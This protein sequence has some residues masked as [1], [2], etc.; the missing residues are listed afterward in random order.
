MRTH[1]KIKTYIRIFGGNNLLKDNTNIS[2]IFDFCKYF[3]GYFL[4]N[5][6]FIA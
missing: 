1:L 6:H 5:Q 4:D 3:G 2:K